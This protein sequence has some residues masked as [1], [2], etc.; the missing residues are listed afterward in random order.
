MKPFAYAVLAAV[1]PLVLGGG[2][3]RAAV[4]PAHDVSVKMKLKDAKTFAPLAR[5]RRRLIPHLLRRALTLDLPE[6]PR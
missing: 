4:K 5:P 6:G 2:A 3:A 1:A